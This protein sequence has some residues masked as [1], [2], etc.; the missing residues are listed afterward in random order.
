MAARGEHPIVMGS[1]DDLNTALSGKKANIVVVKGLK[2][3]KM[4][5]V[6]Y[7]NLKK[8]TNPDSHISPQ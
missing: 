7:R 4:P 8:N 2:D 1:T 6:E 5:L 3:K